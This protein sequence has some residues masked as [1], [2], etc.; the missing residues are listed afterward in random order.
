MKLTEGRGPNLTVVTAFQGLVLWIK[1]KTG[2]EQNTSIH[3]SPL[4][5]YK[6]NVTRTLT[7]LQ[8]HLFHCDE[9][10]PK[11]AGQNEPLVP[12]V[13]FVK[14]FIIVMRKVTNTLRETKDDWE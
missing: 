10:H 6:C 4:P 1:Y 2:S 14:C 7:L 11:T 12:Q 8:P 9:S 3:L 13:A 5:D